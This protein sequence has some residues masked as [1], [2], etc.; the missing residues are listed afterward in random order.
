MGR[1]A[2][3]YGGRQTVTRREP[4]AGRNSR[5][6]PEIRARRAQTSLF[7][8]SKRLYFKTS[9]LSQLSPNH[10]FLTNAATLINVN[11][12]KLNQFI[13]SA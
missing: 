6:G 2:K 7:S 9:E 10:L 8:R 12:C 5:T 1:L 3:L 11:I 4:S 13:A